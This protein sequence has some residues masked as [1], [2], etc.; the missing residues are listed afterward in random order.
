MPKR[1]PLRLTEYDYRQN[2]AYFVTLCT[3]N[4]ISLFGDI[5]FD[6]PL[7]GA[8]LCVRPNRPDLIVTKWLKEIENKY[9]NVLI[10][11]F[12]I[13][14]DHIHFI[15]LK[16]G[17]HTGA[18]LPEIIKWFKTQTTNDYINSVKSGLF[19]PFE[20]HIWQ[21]NYFEHIIRNNQDLHETRKYIAENPIR[22][23]VK[24]NNGQR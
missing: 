5:N 24:A 18:P 16:T 22:W 12:V 23:A 13:M 19:P 2:G 9:N 4:R 6:G 15:I 14:P 10:D 11:T 7:V 8:H 17:A 21:R 20:K 1:K 3:Y